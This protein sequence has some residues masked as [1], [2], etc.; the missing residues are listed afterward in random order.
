MRHR[1]RV[2]RPLQLFQPEGQKLVECRK[3]RAEI[4]ILPDVGLQQARMI[5]HAVEYLRRSETVACKLA[6]EIHRSHDSLRPLNH[7]NCD[8]EL[9]HMTSTKVEFS[10][11]N[12]GISSRQQLVLTGRSPSLSTIEK[13][14][15]VSETEC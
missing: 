3:L 14:L 11:Y 12:Q 9:R 4:V 6:L 5:G 13:M 8:R 7:A 1:H 2:Q 15:A 10:S